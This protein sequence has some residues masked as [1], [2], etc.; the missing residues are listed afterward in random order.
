MLSPAQATRRLSAASVVRDDDDD[1]A[2]LTQS[3]REL[4]LT[5]QSDKINRSPRVQTASS[6]LQQPPPSRRA[7]TTSV[8]PRL[9]S[10]SPSQSRDARASRA[11][12]P[13]LIRKASLN[14][15]QSASRRSSSAQLLSSAPKSAPLPSQEEEKP[16]PTAHSLAKTHLKAE[17]D[18]HH[19]LD[20]KLSTD[21]IVVLNDAVYGHRFSRPRTSRNALSTIVERPERIK[22]SVLG[23][24]TAYVRLGGRHLDGRSPI[25]PETNAQSLSSVPFRIRKTERRLPLA[26]PAVTNV[27]GTKW[28]DELK[29]MCDSAESKLAMGGK[30]LQRP[31][32]NRGTD[33]APPTKLH[34]GDL[35]L[36]SESLNALEGALGAVCEA[37]D[38]VFTSG[39]KRAFVGVRP[40]GHHC[41]ASHPSGFCWVNNVHVGIMH[42]ALTHGLTHAA[43]IDFDLHHGDGSQAITWGHNSRAVSAPKNASAWKKTSIGYFSIHDINSYPCEMGDEEKVKNASLCIENAHGQTIW[44][45]HLESWKD[46]RDFWRLYESK[47]SLLLDKTRSYLRQQASRLKALN[48]TPKAAIFFSAGFDA[49]EWEGLGMQRHQVNVPTDFYARLS[50]D[51]VK[52]AAEED[53]HVDGRVISVLEGGYSDRALCSGVLSHLSGLVGRPGQIPKYPPEMSAEGVSPEVTV[54]T[55]PSPAQDLIYDPSWWAA[56]ELDRLESPPASPSPP[57]KPRNMTPPTYSSPTQAS[58]AKVVDPERMRRSLSGLSVPRP[59]ERAPTPPPPEVSWVI[60]AHELSRLLIPSGRQTDSCK[61]EDLNAEATRARRDRQSILM[62][63]PPL[64]PEPTSRPTS[65]MALRDRKPKLVTP[66]N[67]DV[68]EKAAKSRRKTVGVP[69]VSRD[70]PAARANS[71]LSNDSSTTRTTG[72]RLS[73]TSPFV[74]KE[75]DSSLGFG[76][77]RPGSVTSSRTESTGKLA[78]KKTRTTGS[79][80]KDTVT[81]APRSSKKSTAQVTNA[82]VRATTA[83]IPR[84]S[85]APG[86]PSTDLDGALEGITKGIKKIK[87]NL[88]TKTQREA[89]EKSRLDAEKSSSPPIGNPSQ[90]ASATESLPSPSAEVDIGLPSSASAG[91]VEM[92]VLPAPAASLPAQP[93]SSPTRMQSPVDPIAAGS[94]PQMTTPDPRQTATP[95][96]SPDAKS[97]DMGNNENDVFV[98]YQ[99]EGPTPV[100]VS[101]QQEPLKW[102]SPN[103]PSSSA[104]TPAVTPSPSRKRQGLFQYTSGIPF[105]PTPGTEQEKPSES[106]ES[107]AQVDKKKGDYGLA[108]VWEVPETPEK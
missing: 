81:K 64:A 53:L 103:V 7:S 6:P 69:S 11:G 88:I 58:T 22:A 65:R 74:K 73:I 38:A 15:L 101:R 28:M 30:E 39:Y 62:G 9:S 47:Y 87:I 75:E 19:G 31:D 107:P 55:T 72:R 37:V 44:N 93:M 43:I 82:A 68:G 94:P 35:Y 67:E 32:I 76:D 71:S 66:V 61:P 96:F 10:R 50:Q 41:S 83:E 90:G 8:R 78:V 49:S 106:S 42:A 100:A 89:R 59:M 57:R 54:D 102:M 4:S 27:H 56:S 14:S 63:I 80:R 98:A 25:Q 91:E 16:P 2:R 33:A 60:A 97:K 40:P 70:E 46:H 77:S 108:S 5:K 85:T 18:A 79:A 13:P 95:L 104:S 26:S 51:V 52:L 3:L 86:P 21:T 20:A 34:E 92:P 48:Q 17:L 36:C 23:I 24:S 105:A 1:D 99:P 12:T 45:V 84:P 29:L